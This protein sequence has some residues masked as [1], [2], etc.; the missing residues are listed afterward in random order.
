MYG[1]VRSRELPVYGAKTLA[2]RH[3]TLELHGTYIS[4]IHL[5]FL[6]VSVILVYLDRIRAIHQIS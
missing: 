6:Q 3:G 4:L 2:V 5:E 1:E